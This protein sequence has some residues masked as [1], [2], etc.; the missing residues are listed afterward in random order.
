MTNDNPTIVPD[1]TYHDAGRASLLPAVQA[2]NDGQYEL[3]EGDGPRFALVGALGKG[4]LG[5]VYAANDRDIGRRVAI[6][7]VRSDRRTTDAMVRFVQEVRTAGQLDHPNIVP[8]HDIGREEDGSYYFVMKYLEGQSLETLIDRLRAGDREAHVFWTFERRVS[9]FRQVLHAIQFAHDRGIVHRDIKPGNIMVGKHGEVHVV[10]WGLAK[11]IGAPSIAPSKV[12]TFVSDSAFN[13]AETRAGALIGTPLYMAPEQ[14]RGEPTDER[15]DV[16]QLALVLYELLTLR[17]YIEP[18][19]PLA[20]I[21]EKVQ[22]APIR[23]PSLIKYRHQQTPPAELSWFVM[24]GLARDPNQR[25]QTVAEMIETL[26]QRAD[27]IFKVV[28]PVTLTKRVLHGVLRVIDAHPRITTA[29][30]LSLGLSVVLTGVAAA[31]GAVI[32]LGGALIALG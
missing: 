27:G 20:A 28:C 8:I 22:N 12:L 10:D 9:L 16:W 7:R 23:S 25:F 17:H 32:A 18:D 19:L 29:V 21:L 11:R 2:R 6:K 26:D 31:G 1:R 30:A 24:K 14:A 15:T 4:G 3:V 5:E 13:S